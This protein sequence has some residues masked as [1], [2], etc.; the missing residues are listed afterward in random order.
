[1]LVEVEKNVAKR[2][3]SSAV[4]NDLFTVSHP[5][6]AIRAKSWLDNRLARGKSSMA[7]EMM[8]VTPA[9]AEHILSRCN[10]ANR[11]L[12]ESRVSLYANQMKTGEW[13]RTAQTISISSDGRLNNGQ[14]R[15][16]AIMQSGMP[17]N[18]IVV[19]GE[20]ADAF[21]VTDIQ[22]PRSAGD[23]LHISGYANYLHLAACARLAK[24]IVEREWNTDFTYTNE[25]ILSFVQKNPDLVGAL[26]CG[27]NVAKKLGC[28]RG[29]VGTAF[30][31]I[32]V[33]KRREKFDLFFEGLVTGE[34][35]G[36][37]LAK[38][39]DTIKNKAWYEERA[40]DSRSLNVSL[41]ATVV[42][43]W[44]QYVI[45]RKGLVKF[46]YKTFPEVL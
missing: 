5:A 29:A 34:N 26:K 22:R 39:R 30:W 14:H 15:L 40:R 43:G 31:L 23:S 16:K 11:P 19:F 27:A 41:A 9:I 37:V 45:G 1:M 12:N 33:T 13:K 44:N 8:T 38:L 6:D 18:F 24:A 25:E 7:A 21:L 10:T 36:P 2:H 20:P 32:N 4:S 28:S 35:L 3:A 17:I 42:H 46:D